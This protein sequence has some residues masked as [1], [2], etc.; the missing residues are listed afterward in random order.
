MV[1]V[2]GRV[3]SVSLRLGTV[4]DKRNLPSL[5]VNQFEQAD[6]EKCPWAIRMAVVGLAQAELE[7][8]RLI[9]SCQPRAHHQTELPETGHFERQE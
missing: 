8:R 7:Q 5:T 3:A 2:F 6:L 1:D 9:P 4:F